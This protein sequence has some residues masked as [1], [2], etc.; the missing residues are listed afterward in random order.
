VPCQ[1]GL[2]FSGLP[3]Q[4]KKSNK[5]NTFCVMILTSRPP[6]NFEFN[7]FHPRK[8]EV[9][10]FYNGLH[11]KYKEQLVFNLKTITD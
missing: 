5:K 10:K 8:I 11:K 1:A 2:L 7:I 4:W 9:S 3:A 6:V